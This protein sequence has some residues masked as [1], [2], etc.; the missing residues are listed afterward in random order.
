MSLL[1]KGSSDSYLGALFDG[2]P[3]N[4]GGHRSFASWL[5]SYTPLPPQ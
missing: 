2:K 4:A 1:Q 3:T 5:T